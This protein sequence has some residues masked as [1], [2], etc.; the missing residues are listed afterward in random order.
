MDLRLVGETDKLGI[1][2]KHP[3]DRFIATPTFYKL[4][5]LVVMSRIAPKGIETHRCHFHEIFNNNRMLLVRKDSF[6]R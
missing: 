6:S 3:N 1:R 4:G 2:L 5:N